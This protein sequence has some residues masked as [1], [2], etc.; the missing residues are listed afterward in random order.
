MK[1]LIAA[2]ST[3]AVLGL[4]TAHAQFSLPPLLEVDVTIDGETKTFVFEDRDELEA[5][6]FEEFLLANFGISSL[7]QADSFV[8]DGAAF[9]QQF[10]YFDFR[11]GVVTLQAQFNDVDAF[12][13]GL[14]LYDPDF[15]LND[16]SESERDLLDTIL[17][18]A[19]ISFRIDDNNDGPS[20]DFLDIGNGDIVITFDEGSDPGDEDD[21]LVIN[22][23]GVGEYRY[24]D[25]FDGSVADALNDTLEDID[26]DNEKVSKLL[27]LFTDTSVSNTFDDPIAGNPASVVGRM[28]GVLSDMH[29]RRLESGKKWGF[30]GQLEAESI[31]FDSDMDADVIGGDLAV[32]FAAGPGEL[33]VT[34]PLAYIEYDS[35]VEVGH[36]GVI[37]GY[38]L[39][40]N[41]FIT[42]M[43]WEWTAQANLGAVAGSS[44]AIAD[45][46]LVSTF[47]VTNRFMSTVNE[48]LDMG[49]QLDVN[50]FGSP[51]I[52]IDGYTQ[53][54][55][56]GITNVTFGAIAD[57][58]ADF[59]GQPVDLI[60]A[61]RRAE[62]H[63]DDLAID[64]QNEIDFQVRGSKYVSGG[65]T[66]GFGDDYDSIGGKVQVRF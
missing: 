51:D 21:E 66:F 62:F 39:D 30:F 34:V 61:V 63:G 53:S 42:D 25:D 19:P 56:L 3:S 22:I 7:D 31:S 59:G 24:G 14:E 26:G 64:A 11:D 40:M 28:P 55:D 57:Y 8:L 23:K 46:A 20:S 35:D 49:W 60:L 1:K 16:L 13:Q 12:F 50:Y 5:Q 41:D 38:A 33:S 48:K 17:E 18:G 43:P 65:L 47:G 54:Y 10:E 37:L 27:G 4:G 36:A 52:E 15:D 44:D 32:H 58:T 9:G 6:S 45:A 2:L 29:E